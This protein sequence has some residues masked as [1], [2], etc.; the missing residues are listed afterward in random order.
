MLDGARCEPVSTCGVL[1]SVP[2]GIRIRTN[3]AS[4]HAQRQLGEAT[5]QLGRSSARLASGLR[6]ATA[7][8]DAAGLGIGTRMRVEV[9]SLRVARRNVQ[10]GVSLLQ[11]ADGA[12]S[13]IGDLLSRSSELALRSMT[14][15][16]QASDRDALE[17]ERGQ[18]A[19]EI[20]RIVDTTSFQGELLFAQ[21]SR[22]QSGGIGIQIGTQEGD[23]VEIEM[24]GLWRLARVVE[25]LRVD[26]PIA[27]RITRFVLGF[28]ADIVNEARGELG[29]V[30][31]RLDAAGREL[32]SREQHTADAASRVMDAD[33]AAESA[34]QMRL[35]ILQHAATSVLAQA[36]TQPLLALALLRQPLPV[37]PPNAGPSAGPAAGPGVGP[38]EQGPARPAAG[39]L[40]GSTGSNV[41][42]IGGAPGEPPF[43]WVTAPR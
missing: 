7:A 12:L 10:D 31:R 33:L 14:E 28:G 18:L 40:N 36:N 42:S 35:V 30:S 22:F 20:A 32:A 29:A 16:L 41:S 15:T 21:G 6:I 17:V 9:R 11:V 8:D 4:V 37:A 23:R 43:P 5:R 38:A 34:E 2:M 26:H 39:A 25:R 24:P 27:A 3:V 1:R 13:E 19:E